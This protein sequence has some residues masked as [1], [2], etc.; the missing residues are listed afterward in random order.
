[1]AELARS[2]GRRSLSLQLQ[3]NQMAQ[4]GGVLKLQLGCGAN[5]LAG[6]LNTDSMPSPSVDYLDFT[7]RFPFGDNIFAAI[8]CEHTIEHIPKS[9]AQ[10]TI[11]E[12]YRV[13]RP[14]GGFRVVTPSLEMLGQLIVSQE[15]PASQKYLAWFR[16][17]ANNPNA[18]MADAINLVF[19]GHGHCHIYSRDDLG[20]LLQQAG[21][22]DLRAM[23][24][25][26]YAD[27]VFHGVDGH[28]R[29]IGE[30]IAAMEAFAIEAR[31]P[32]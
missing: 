24:A 2:N 8:F 27:A 11:N 14:G 20:G 22:R 4:G 10:A 23:P 3:V 15:S 1:M 31:K 18:T 28:G 12:V 30:D 6:W 25:G 7:K 29:V 16:K 5:I 19:Y 26:T 9:Q 21:F 17:Y 13:L 32:N